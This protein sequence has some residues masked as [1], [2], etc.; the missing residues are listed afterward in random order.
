MTKIDFITDSILDCNNSTALFKVN[1]KSLSSLAANEILLILDQWVANTTTISTGISDIKIS[2][3]CH[4]TNNSVASNNHSDEVIIC[5]NAT[6]TSITTVTPDPAVPIMRDDSNTSFVVV[7][8][9]MS[10]TTVLM[11]I[12]LIAVVIVTMKYIRYI[13]DECV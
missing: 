4:T 11:V 7:C 3:Q 9:L 8:V 10:L 1:I 2:R 12:S 6:I 13:M 5:S